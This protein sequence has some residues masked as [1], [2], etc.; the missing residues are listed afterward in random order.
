MESKMT[1][2]REPT[3]HRLFDRLSDVARWLSIPQR[4][5]ENW[6]ASGLIEARRDGK[7]STRA[8]WAVAAAK[9]EAEEE[10]LLAGEGEGGEG[11]PALERWRR[12]KA[13]KEELLL[14][15]LKGELVR[16]PSVEIAL[17]RFTE[18]V[19]SKLVSMI[20]R[21]APL[22]NP[23]NPKHAAEVLDREVRAALAEVEAEMQNVRIE[24]V[25]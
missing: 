3:R 21:A 4:T 25:E 6:R 16:K 1:T 12:A 13:E 11:G 10:R 15:E 14:A 23:D 5:L 9:L 19:K 2:W 20:N 7:W 22:M 24:G 8:V 18:T 17:T